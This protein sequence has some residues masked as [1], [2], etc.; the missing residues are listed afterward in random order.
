MTEGDYNK[1]LKELAE[2]F[3]SSFSKVFFYGSKLSNSL[4]NDFVS[5]FNKAK[6]IDIDR[7]ELYD[8]SLGLYLSKD[9]G[10]LVTDDGLFVTSNK[11]SYVI[12][13]NDLDKG[14][15]FE[16][17]VGSDRFIIETNGKRLKVEV[18]DSKTNCDKFVKFVE[19][20]FSKQC[21]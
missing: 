3:N 13:Y 12:P 7:Q 6:K 2:T 5:Q 4:I 14:L 1:E 19:Q 18:N 21:K 11:K 8:M 17:K 20:V 15:V 9:D 16:K 10:I